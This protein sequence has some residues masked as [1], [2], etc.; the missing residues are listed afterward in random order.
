M[1]IIN[2]YLNMFRASLCPKHVGIEVN[3]K[4]IIVAF[5]G[6]FLFKIWKLAKSMFDKNV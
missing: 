4:H 3:N 1:F 6:F 2:F 5:V